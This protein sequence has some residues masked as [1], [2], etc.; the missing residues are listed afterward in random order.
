[1]TAAFLSAIITFSGNILPIFEQRCSQCHNAQAMP[2]RNWLDY[3]TA[4]KFRYE[5][6][7]RV[8]NLRTMPMTGTM[9]DAEREIV[10]E[11]VDE[12]AKK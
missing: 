6:K 1:M 11:W 3:D 9:T 2:D 10:K 7:D 12:G 5:I 4:Y 8:Y